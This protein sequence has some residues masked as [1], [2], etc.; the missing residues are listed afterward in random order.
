MLPGQQPTRIEDELRERIVEPVDEVFF[1]AAQIHGGNLAQ[2]KPRRCRQQATHI[3]IEACR[4]PRS[5]LHIR[6]LAARVESVL[7][8]NRDIV[9][10]DGRIGPVSVPDKVTML[11]PAVRSLSDSLFSHSVCPLTLTVNCLP[12]G[13]CT[14]KDCA[15]VFTLTYRCIEAIDVGAGIAGT[16]SVDSKGWRH[17]TGDRACAIDCD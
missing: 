14:T 17:R 2:R 10:V 3:E 16:H 1:V 12:C 4:R 6:D 15:V 8:K 9:R 5:R 13:P 11:L 7:G